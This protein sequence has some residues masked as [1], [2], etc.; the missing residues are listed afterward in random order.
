MDKKK[1]GVLSLFTLI[2]L[3]GIAYV[4]AARDNPS[5]PWDQILGMF[6]TNTDEDPIPVSIEESKYV[7]MILD[8]S[9]SVSEII[10]LEGF[11]DLQISYHFDLT[12]DAAD[13]EGGALDLLWCTEDGLQVGGGELHLTYNSYPSGV[14]G[15]QSAKIKSNYL[16]INTYNDIVH[17][18]DII[19]LVL[20]ATK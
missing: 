12:Y 4:S 17:E 1:I 9:G 16:Q 15:T 3:F 18:G 13:P 10:S 2:I 11:E 14:Y 7:E 19:T 20:Y 5:Q 8:E 6:I